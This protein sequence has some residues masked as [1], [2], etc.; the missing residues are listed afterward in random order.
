MILIQGV[1]ELIKERSVSAREEREREEEKGQK[2]KS[3]EIDQI[4]MYGCIDL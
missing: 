1:K 4:E 2:K 3:V